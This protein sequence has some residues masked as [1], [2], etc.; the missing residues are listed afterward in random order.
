MDEVVQL[1]FAEREA[2]L[3]QLSGEVQE[4]DTLIDALLTP[5]LTTPI[6]LDRRR[7]GA[8]PED[9]EELAEPLG[10]AL[11]FAFEDRPEDVG[12]VWQVLVQRLNE[13]AQV[14]RQ[15]DLQGIPAATAAQV[16][17]VSPL[18][19][20]GEGDAQAI[21]LE[22]PMPID[23][24][25]GQSLPVLIPGEYGEAGQWYELAPALPSNPFGQL[26]FYIPGWWREPQVG[27]YW[28]CGNPRGEQIVFPDHEPVDAT[29]YRLAGVRAGVFGG[30]DKHVELVVD[31]VGARE[32]GLVALARAVDWLTLR[33]V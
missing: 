10:E 6:A 18:D 11:A 20:T 24:L 15:A 16:T 23:Y 4:A 21:Y 30:V 5:S 1:S 17:A 26:V 3:S 8:P 9:Y 13:M 19:G 12:Q 29:G 2:L 31:A 14:A 22:A 25:P 33:E 32:P 27:E 7:L 28:T